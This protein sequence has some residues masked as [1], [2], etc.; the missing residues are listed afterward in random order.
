MS[1]GFYSVITKQQTPVEWRE[2][3]NNC[4]HNK[5]KQ[6]KTKTTK[7]QN[8]T[9]T[10]KQQNKTKQCTNKAN[11]VETIGEITQHNKIQNIHNTKYNM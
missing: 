5:T 7:Q 4:H 2:C 11:I 3:Q 10:T 8:K 9:K 6:N 1:N